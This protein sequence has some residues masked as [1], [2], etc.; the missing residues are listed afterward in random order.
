MADYEP[1]ERPFHSDEGASAEFGRW[2]SDYISNTTSYTSKWYA[3]QVLA[4]CKFETLTASLISRTGAGASALLSGAVVGNVQEI[5]AGVI[6]YGNFTTIKLY[7]GA[8]IA[9]KSQ[10]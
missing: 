3:I 8:I 7:S 5:P 1:N 6:I 4:N 10:S 2:G 9:Y